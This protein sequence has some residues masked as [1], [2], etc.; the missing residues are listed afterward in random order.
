MCSYAVKFADVHAARP[1]GPQMLFYYAF[2]PSPLASR[3][4]ELLGLVGSD[5]ATEAQLVLID[6][7]DD[8]AFYISTS[9]VINEASIGALIDG[10]QTKT[11]QRQEV[12]M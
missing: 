4:R 12:A 6:L 10:Y 8:G 3:V 11:L 1:G 7:R 5:S 2:R 9:N